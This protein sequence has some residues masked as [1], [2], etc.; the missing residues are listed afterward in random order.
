M[1]ERKKDIRDAYIYLPSK[2]MIYE[3]SFEAS[4]LLPI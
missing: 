4:K 1:R 3:D 2:Y